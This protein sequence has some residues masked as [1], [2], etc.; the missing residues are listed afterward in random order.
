[1]ASPHP[2][3]NGQHSNS[4]TINVEEG[5]EEKGPSSL[6]VGMKVIKSMK[7]NRTKF[8]KN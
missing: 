7:E 5:I 1:M 8:I 2:R 4:T 3:H 6:L